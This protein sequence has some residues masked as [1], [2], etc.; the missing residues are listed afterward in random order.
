MAALTA[1]GFGTFGNDEPL[2]LPMPGLFAD[3]DS[4]TGSVALTDE[5]LEAAP[6]ARAEVLRQWLRALTLHRNAALVDMF[7]EF[8]APLREL[9]IVEQIARFRE[10]CG[11]RGLDCPADFAGL[12]QR[13]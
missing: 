8:S 12:L 1:T 13:F 11:H 10:V 2:H 5:F 7:R 4:G 3:I 9:T 6:S